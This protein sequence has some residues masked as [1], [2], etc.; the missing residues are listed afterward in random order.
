MITLWLLLLISWLMHSG[1][2]MSTL[3]YLGTPHLVKLLLVV[4]LIGVIL[5]ILV[6][7][8][9]HTIID[10]LITGGQLID[11]RHT[12]ELMSELVNA[13]Q[14]GGQPASLLQEVGSVEVL[15]MR[16]LGLFGL[17]EGGHVLLVVV[18]GVVTLHLLWLGPLYVHRAQHA[19]LLGRHHVYG[20]YASHVFHS[21]YNDSGL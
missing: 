8:L 6:L 9:T 18:G 7:L 13:V 14:H 1:L 11:R 16:Q 4:S 12:R 17:F 3:L 10:L 20:V 5:I 19:V 21:L 15:V 2:L